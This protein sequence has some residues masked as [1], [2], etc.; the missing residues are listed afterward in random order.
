MKTEQTNEKKGVNVLNISPEQKNEIKELKENYSLTDKGVIALLL[1]VAHNNSVGLMPDDDGEGVHEVDALQVIVDGLNLAKKGKVEK[2]K[3][4]DEE[5]LA[6]KE[7]RK[8]E[9]AKVKMELL[10]KKLKAEVNG[11]TE[12]EETEPLVEIGV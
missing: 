11:T 9:R 7:A 10:I 6:R 5:K 8:Q 12:E 4:T 1:E 2:I 3:L